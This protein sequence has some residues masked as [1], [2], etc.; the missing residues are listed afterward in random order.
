MAFGCDY[1]PEQWP[2]EVW[3]EDVRLMQEAGVNLVSVAIFSWALLEPEEGRFEFGWLDDILELLTAGGIKVDLATAT[4]SPPPWLSHRYPETLP[5][6][7]EGLRLSPG[8]RQAWCPSSPVF[9]EKAL[10][11]VEMMANRYRDHPGVVM[12]H[13]SNE[14]GCHNAHCYCDVSAEAF[15]RWLGERYGS[16]DALNVA[17]GTTFWSQRYTSWEQ[18]LPPRSAPAIPN[19]TQ[20]LDFLRFSS[21]ELLSYYRS[22]RD[23]LRRLTPQIPVT[24]NF[25]VTSH[26]NAVD[27]RSWAGDM[28]VIANDHYLNAADPAGYLEL[29]FS[30]DVTR[31]LA[32]GGAWLLMEQSTSAVNWQPRNV[33]KRPGELLRNSLQHVAR[34]ADGI[35]FFQWRASQAGAEK[36]HSALVPHAG[37]D[38]KVWREVSELGTALQRLA[39][40]AGTRVTAEVALLFDWESWWAC[41]LGSHPSVDVKYLDRAHALY[42][43][44]WHAG[45]TADIVHPDSDLSGY[46]L[47][48]VPTLYLATDQTRDSVRSFV[49]TGG[50]ACVTYFSGIVDENDHVRLGGYPGAFRELLG[51]TVEE[52]LPLR[53]QERVNLD[54]ASSAD[55][56]VELMQVRD[57][58]AISSYLDGPAAGGPAI[59]RR[60]VGTG[61]AWYVGTRLD[62]V[63]TERLVAQLLADS[64][65]VAAQTPKGLEI[66]RRRSTDRSYLFLLNHTDE[67][68]V[69][70]AVS[71]HDL[72][73]G[74]D[75]VGSLTLPPGGTAVLREAAKR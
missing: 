65:V 11:L 57:A 4:A 44:L 18:I 3:E 74:R 25:M 54:D 66:V 6:T 63:G 24:T 75:Y 9:R 48:I 29:A 56:W 51:V 49:E 1:N 23:V 61:S 31:G 28:D 26:F 19:P 55:V 60:A 71:G 38:T 32:E 68:T 30:A 73:S 64:G 17:W 72:L 40:V 34:G 22:E 27:Y 20:Q 43:A 39:E 14:L 69:V 52:F 13:V 8:G 5:V 46:R 58:Q 42:R 70:E 67:E 15:R 7:R 2:R 59:T 33:A 16:L 36:F 53:E 45:V 62:D 21:A 41:E 10:V 50:T 12:W 47:V 37:T 35:C